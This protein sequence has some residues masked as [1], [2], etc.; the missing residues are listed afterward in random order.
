MCPQQRILI[1][2]LLECR[3][4][5]VYQSFCLLRFEDQT[6][7]FLSIYNIDTIHS[8]GYPCFWFITIKLTLPTSS[9]FCRSGSHILRCKAKRSLVTSGWVAK[10]LPND[11]MQTLK[12]QTELTSTC[13]TCG[14]EISKHMMMTVITEINCCKLINLFSHLNFDSLSPLTL[15]SEIPSMNSGKGRN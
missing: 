3:L 9:Y 11:L 1:V 12:E 2:K 13:N 6:L 15:N 5:F 8:N 14:T 4:I 10:S 7:T